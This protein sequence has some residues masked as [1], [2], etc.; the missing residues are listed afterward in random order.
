MLT[1]IRQH[2]A[3]N[4]VGYVALVVSL[5]FGSAWA[6]TTLTKNE[7]K[8]KNIAPGAVKRSDIAANAVNSQKVA[9]GSLL[10]AD[11]ASGQLPSGPT[12]AMGPTGVQGATGPTG[13]AGPTGP[14]GPATGPAGGDLTGNY[15]NPSIAAGAVDPGELA[16]APAV[17]AYDVFG[18]YDPTGPSCQVSVDSGNE[19]A[20][21]FANENYD[22]NGM[23]DTNYVGNPLASTEFSAPISGLY[24]VSAGLIWPSTSVVGS[25]QLNIRTQFADYVASEQ[26]AA[27]PSGNAT[28][29]NVHG[30]VR[31]T[32]GQFV[33]ATAFQNSGGNLTPISSGDQRGFFAMEW[34]GP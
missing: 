8:S 33:Y 4:V 24:S 27:G 30:T 19:R 14:T 31:L 3:S 23:H 25:R 15:P 21:C 5:T 22:S 20:L 28:I 7:V 11:F 9:D 32:A 26:V 12:G 29:L 2:A 6:A 18:S 16:A 1:R 13:A 34:I 10:S 17:R